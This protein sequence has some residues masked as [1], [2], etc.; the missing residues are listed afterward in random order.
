MDLISRQATIDALW[1]ALF[2]YE[3]KTEKQFIETDELD[4][5]DWVQHRVF[6]QN[7]NDIDR[8]TILDLPSAD[9]VEVVRCKYCKHSTEWYGDKRRCF[10]CCEDGIDVFEDGYCSYWERKNDE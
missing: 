8:Q 4:V 1:K 6:V 10:L 3:D 2:E 5:E 9:A 7:M